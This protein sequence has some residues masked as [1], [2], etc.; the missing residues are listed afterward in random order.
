MMR[1]RRTLKQ[2][3]SVKLKRK[4]VLVYATVGIAVFTIV[5][6]GVFFYLNFGTSTSSS[7]KTMN[8]QGYTSQDDGPYD[9]EDNATWTKTQT[10]MKD[11]PGINPN[12]GYIHIYGYV[13]RTGDLRIASSTDLTV[14][15]TLWVTGDLTV[16][17]G[18]SV[19]IGPNGRLVVEG[20][21]TTNGGADN[22]NQGKSVVKQDL[23]GGGGANFV[24][25]RDFYVF[26]T[27]SRS[28]G[29][30]FNRSRNTSA[31]NIQNESSMR[32]NDPEFYTFATSGISTLPVTL[33]YFRGAPE[34]KQVK[35]S[36]ETAEEINNDY[37]TIERSSD[38]TRFEK[39]I[40]IKGLGNSHQPQSYSY[41]DPY[42]LEG[43]AYYRL[44]QTDFDGKF[45]VF[46]AIAVSRI[47]PSEVQIAPTFH[48]ASPNP[49]TSSFRVS[50][51]APASGEVLIQLL[52]FGGTVV[53]SENISAFTGH[54][55]Y[56]F[57]QGDRL[58]NGIYLLQLTQN[59]SSSKPVR[60]IKR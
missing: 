40:T 44:R 3:P 47:T 57:Y 9:W 14:F 58:N 18:G 34:G 55:Q 7:A 49:F 24:N 27:T 41:L 21:Y 8:T 20:K 60:V 30:S 29:S 54:N 5:G 25:D 22:H 50:F 45:E 46:N 53:F 33:T 43:V 19:T 51:D 36:W 42:P 52:D 26:G 35:L 11:N 23:T 28:G 16:T 17:G 37:F 32:S 39:V 1:K 10:W 2:R 13:T 31:S 15:D 59:G 12:T 38:G 6:I 56:E 4:L 48:S